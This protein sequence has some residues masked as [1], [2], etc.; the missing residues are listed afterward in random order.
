[1]KTYANVMIQNEALILP[2]VYQYWKDY[3]IDKWVFYDD[4]STDST[5]SVIKSLFGN[6]AT[7]IEGKR[8]KFSES[9]NRSQML[10][11]SRDNGAEF[12]LAIDAD[13]LLSTSWLKNWETILKKNIEFDV[14]Y[15]WYNVVGDIKTIRQ[16]P[17]YLHNYRTFLLP[18]SKT[19]KFDM[20]QF[21]YHTSR[22][23][24]VNLPSTQSKE[25]GV[26]HLQAINKRYYALKQ[27]WYKHY[28]YH[29]WNHSVEFINSR[30][31]PV[32][33]NMN[34][35]EK[36]IPSHINDNINFNP[37]I[38]DEIEKVKGYKNYILKNTVEKL[39]TFGREYLK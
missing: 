16:D 26:I 38:Y 30:Y 6:R 14:K 27:L 21:K 13:E 15:Y 2:Y 31:D 33:N 19:S 35:S 39:I 4:N 22:T 32:I 28:E 11:L 29:T 5:V 23:P 17:M 9:H 37:D 12:V 36:P 25:A 3:P 18:M 8:E 7:V 20:N 24:P 10:E 34:F 1:M